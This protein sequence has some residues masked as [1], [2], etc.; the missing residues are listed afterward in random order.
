MS[1]CDVTSWCGICFDSGQL[2][3]AISES[4]HS[5]W[6]S[7]VW[8]WLCFFFTNCSTL[9]C[10]P[11]HTFEALLVLVFVF[12]LD[13]R[14]DGFWIPRLRLRFNFLLASAKLDCWKPIRNEIQD[15]RSTHKHALW[16]QGRL[17]FGKWHW[18]PV[19]LVML[20]RYALCTRVKWRFWQRLVLF[21]WV[22]TSWI[23][24]RRQQNEWDTGFN[25]VKEELCVCVPPPQ[26]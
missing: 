10:C 13:S 9:C 20:R 7:G 8:R 22:G 24:G 4:P 2:G 25:G 14:S 5:A 11:N 12:A 19:I 17:I 26:K 23:S 21:W 1:E 6:T 15:I 18:L 16:E 3:L